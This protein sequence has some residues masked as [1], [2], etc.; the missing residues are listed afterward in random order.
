MAKKQR[1]LL[2]WITDHCAGKRKGCHSLSRKVKN[3]MKPAP[4]DLSSDSQL[5]LTPPHTSTPRYLWTPTK[6]TAGSAFFC[7]DPRKIRVGS[8]YQA[9]IPDQIT[10]VEQVAEETGMS[11]P[12]YTPAENP[13]EEERRERWFREMTTVYPDPEFLH[14]CVHRTGWFY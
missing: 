4:L 9:T 13:I 11:R 10:K 8:E 3:K 1:R 2:Y 14:H 5:T 6:G 12:L 7:Q